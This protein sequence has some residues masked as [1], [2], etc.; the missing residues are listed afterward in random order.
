MPDS[1]PVIIADTSCLIILNKIGEL[2][3]LKRLFTQVIITPKIAEEYR[4]DLP[5]WVTI[6]SP[7]EKSYRAI[8]EILDEGEASAIAL[9]LESGNSRLILDDIRAR[10]YAKRLNL[11]V[12]GTLGIIALAQ[13]EGIISSALDLV[14]K[15]QK[16]NFRLSERVL[17]RIKQE[18]NKP[19]E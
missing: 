19:E 6:A 4:H 5:A 7:N 15:I 2:D 12:T 17:E 11:S 1:S 13:K 3:L 8:A 18:L 16:T 9:A 14:E 10:R